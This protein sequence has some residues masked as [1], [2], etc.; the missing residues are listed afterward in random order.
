LD[1]RRWRPVLLFI[2][3]AYWGVY[4]MR[5]RVDGDYF[6]YYY[7]KKNEKVDHLSYWGV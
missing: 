2:N 1:F 5:E 3:G 4:D 7:G 6:K